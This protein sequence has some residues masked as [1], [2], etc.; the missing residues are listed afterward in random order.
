MVLRNDKTAQLAMHEHAKES[1]TAAQIDLMSKG[2]P[3]AINKLK[4]AKEFV[5]SS[6]QKQNIK[7]QLAAS[8]TPSAH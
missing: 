2:N 3:S 1:Y 7:E 4:E 8:E 6:F 5:K